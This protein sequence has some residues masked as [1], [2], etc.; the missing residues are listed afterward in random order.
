MGVFK[1]TFA[2]SLSH[3]IWRAFIVPY[4]NR[5]DNHLSLCLESSDET[6]QA[7]WSMAASAGLLGPWGLEAGVSSGLSV[8]RDGS[9]YREGWEEGTSPQEKEV[10]SPQHWDTGNAVGLPWRK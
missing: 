9:C 7:P 10:L 3:H 6:W 5:G 4:V 2:L 1:W 8:S